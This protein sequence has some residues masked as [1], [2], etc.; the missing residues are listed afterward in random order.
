[1]PLMEVSF[2]NKNTCSRKESRPSPRQQQFTDRRTDQRNRVALCTDH[3]YSLAW[4]ENALV[5]N[6]RQ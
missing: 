2:V 5:A 1:M 4:I 6:M 3:L